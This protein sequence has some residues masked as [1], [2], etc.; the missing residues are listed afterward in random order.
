M[1]I[2]PPPKPREELSEEQKS[3]LHAALAD[4][5]LVHGLYDGER[6][7]VVQG[8]DFEPFFGGTPL[9]DSGSDDGQ[10][11][12]PT[13]AN[14]SHFNL[15]GGEVSVA[16]WLR[17]SV[18]GNSERGPNPV[19]F[20]VASLRT[21]FEALYEDRGLGEADR[22]DTWIVKLQPYTL[23]WFV[24]V[25]MS[26]F[27][28]LDVLSASKGPSDISSIVGC[29][30]RLGRLI[31]HFRWRFAYGEHALR[32]KGTKNAASKGGEAR[33]VNAAAQRQKIITSMR[34]YIA[35]GHS[36]SNA[37]RLTAEKGLGTSQVGNTRLWSR[38]T[39]ARD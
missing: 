13:P 7:F 18:A 39:K 11:Y 8:E 37:A 14:D 3:D 5:L 33:S 10:S 2:E 12:E 20:E 19:V 38:Y 27:E 22:A 36:M 26:E 28:N 30:G 21:Y 15:P 25:I 4:D 35:A 34:E 32:G 9:P 29:V 31:E 6:H 23:N 17:R 24:V 1:G 16:F